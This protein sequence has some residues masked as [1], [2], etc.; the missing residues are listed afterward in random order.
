MPFRGK[1][2]FREHPLPP[3]SRKVPAKVNSS[4]EVEI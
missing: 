4:L 3:W 2:F 1:A